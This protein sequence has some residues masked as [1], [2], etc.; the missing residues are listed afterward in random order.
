MKCNTCN[1][2]IG[3]LKNMKTKQLAASALATALGIGGAVG[4]QEIRKMIPA[5]TLDPMYTNIGLVV[6]G[7]L[8]LPMFGK[9]KSG[10]YMKSLGN[11]MAVEAGLQLV[12]QYLMPATAVSGYNNEG[13]G[14]YGVNNA[15]P[16]LYGSMPSYP[17][18]N[19]ATTSL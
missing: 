3:K 1:Y 10:D 17:G 14:L 13:P 6:L 7:G 8:A 9:G 11:G 19:G 12:N 2:K 16:G 4:S 15:G 5:E 18:T